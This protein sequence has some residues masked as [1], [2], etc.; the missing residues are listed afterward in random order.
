MLGPTTGGRDAWSSYLTEAFARTDPAWQDEYPQIVV[1]QPSDPQEDSDRPLQDSGIRS[2]IPEGPA[3]VILIASTGGPDHL[4]S[5]LARKRP[6]SS[7]GSLEGVRV[8]VAAPRDYRDAIAGLLKPTKAAFRL[9]D[10]GE[11]I[12]QSLERLANLPGR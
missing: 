2:A 8:Y 5:A 10:T 1:L 7:A 11:P 6:E 3:A 4:L 9:F 12:P